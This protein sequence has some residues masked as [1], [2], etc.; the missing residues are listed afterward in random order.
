MQRDGTS[1]TVRS[2]SAPGRTQ[3]NRR[4]NILRCLANSFIDQ[5]SAAQPCM[6]DS[7]PLLGFTTTPLELISFILAVITVLL[8]IRQVHWGWLFAIASSATYALVFYE[9]RLYGDMGLQ[10]VFIAVSIWGWYQ[11]LHGGAAH[12]VLPVSSLSV[13]GRLWSALAWFSGFILISVFLK[14]FTGTDVPYID[15]FLTAGSLLGQ[16]L[17][18][19]KKMENWHVWIAVDVL[20]IG[21]YVYKNLMLTAVLYALF[22]VLAVIGLRAWQ[23]SLPVVAPALGLRTL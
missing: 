6:N 2:R 10:F 17:L 18:S 16:L 3:P 11:W 4:E 23:T 15:G 9:S 1:Y 22:V 12:R 13:R 5:L 7:I 21:L 20:Y 19:R 14:T 8:N